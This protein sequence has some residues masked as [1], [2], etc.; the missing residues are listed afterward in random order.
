MNREQPAKPSVSELKSHTGFWLRFVSNHVSH[1]F[2]RKLLNSG[3]TVAEWV[4]LREIFDTDEMPPSALAEQ[5]GLTRGAISK[6]IERL[7]LKKLVSRKEGSEDRRYQRIALTP[8][9][10]R[11]VP[12]LAAIADRNDHEFF[13]PLTAKEQESLVTTLKKLVH[14]HN[15][16]K[17]P[18]E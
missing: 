10:R 16:H 17:L 5:T 8:A 7:V 3:V 11:L 1:A 14:V 15:L 12:T 4:V 2:S 13:K 6:L 18:T 9:G